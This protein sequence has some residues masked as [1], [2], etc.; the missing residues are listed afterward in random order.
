[1]W[2][3]IMRPLLQCGRA[4][5]GAETALMTFAIPTEGELQCGRAWIGA[6][7]RTAGARLPAG[8][9]TNAH[10]RSQPFADDGRRYSVIKDRVV[11]VPRVWAPR[12]VT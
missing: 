1:M 7:T 12:Q 5:I 11:G 2:E 3:A 4:W 6:E 10:G 8:M 9:V